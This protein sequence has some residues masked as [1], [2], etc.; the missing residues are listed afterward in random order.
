MQNRDI[1]L[2]LIYRAFLDI[3]LAAKDGNARVAERL[4]DLLHSLPLAMIKCGDDRACDGIVLQDLRKR[5][6]MLGLSQ[7]IETA[8]DDIHANEGT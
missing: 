5:A 6:E 4:S 2:S 1:L 8:M 3:R 7:W